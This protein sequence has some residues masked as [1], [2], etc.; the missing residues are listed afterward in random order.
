MTH[1]SAAGGAERDLDLVRE[2]LSG[3]ATPDS[4]PWVFEEDELL[5]AVRR[6][7]RDDAEWLVAQLSDRTVPFELRRIVF[8][9]TSR[10]R[11][12]AERVLLLERPD[13]IWD[14]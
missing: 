12:E 8:A 4:E 2:V 6:L 14:R 7:E 11:A 3:R 13:G 10:V 5:F 9:D 1:G